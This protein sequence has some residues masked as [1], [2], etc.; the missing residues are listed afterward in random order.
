M[1][2]APGQTQNHCKQYRY[3]CSHHHCS[4]HFLLFLKTTKFISNVL[5]AI[6]KLKLKNSKNHFYNLVLYLPAY[7]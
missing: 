4:R 6:S 7:S 1:S 2:V 5:E 3:H